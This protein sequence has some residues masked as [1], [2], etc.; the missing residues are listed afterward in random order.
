MKNFALFLRAN[1]DMSPES[2]ADPKEIE[3]RAAWLEDVKQ[4]NIV[5]HLG[6]TMP[7]IPTMATT[8][9]SNG[10]E[11]SGAFT[12]EKHFLTGYLII[13]A[14][15]LDDAK[16]IASSNPILKAGGSVEIREII[17]R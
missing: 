5:V 10:D 9:F 12:E 17:L 6:G 4:K 7:P 3:L 2:F 11:K 16:A 8:I 14:K 15:D 1:Y 13:T